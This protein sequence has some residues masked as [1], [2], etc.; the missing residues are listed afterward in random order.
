MRARLWLGCLLA[1]CGSA[2]LA[3]DYPTRTVT[4]IVPSAPGGTLD[5]LGRLMAQAMGPELG[6]SVVIENVTGAGSL[7]GMQRLVRSDPEGHVIGFGNVGSMAANV[8]TTRDLGFDP[9]TDLTPISIV[10]NVP[11]VLAASPRSGIRDLATLLSRIR[12][13]GEGVTFGTPG[14]GTTGH[15][16]P[17]YLFTLVGAKAMLVPYRGAGPAM[18]DLAAGTVDVVIDQTVTMIP[19][20][21]GRT[22][23]ALAVTGSARA[24]QLPDVPTFAEAGV[25]GF[26]MVIWNAIAG[27]KGMPPTVVQRL[28][29]A[30]EAALT[31]PAVASRFADLA[32]T[33]PPPAQR[34]PEAMQRQIAADVDR[35]VQVVRSSGMALQ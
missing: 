19:A 11:M 12:E 34:G 22:A 4:M 20:H 23:V 32:A 2:A 33:M 1:F 26:D 27:P 15:L 6:R 5:A 16:A 35:W 13:R 31:S 8:A 25:P 9:R 30:I 18:S 17:A 21:L 29:L 24:A 28:Q 3:Q 10:A 14:A 7:V